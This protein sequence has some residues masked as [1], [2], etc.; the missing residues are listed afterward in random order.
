MVKKS[1]ILV[2][3]LAASAMA[4]PAALDTSKPAVKPVEDLNL[5]NKPLGTDR[6][7]DDKQGIENGEVRGPLLI[8]DVLG[9]NGDHQEREADAPTSNSK[10]FGFG[11]HHERVAEPERS[12]KEEVSGSGLA[13]RGYA[14]RWRGAPNHPGPAGTKSDPSKPGAAGRGGW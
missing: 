7:L 13:E 4:A 14:D 3:T 11:S 12:D 9:H 5:G 8:D 6:Q 1:T 10:L 2:G